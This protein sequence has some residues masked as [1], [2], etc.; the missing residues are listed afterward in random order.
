MR[1]SK[2]IAHHVLRYMAS[3]AGQMARDF[4]NQRGDLHR[5]RRTKS[6]ERRGLGTDVRV[7]VQCV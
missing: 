1:V 5:E 6:G 3:T 2:I 7:C 4:G